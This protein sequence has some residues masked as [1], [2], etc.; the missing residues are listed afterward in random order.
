[1]L[2]VTTGNDDVSAISVKDGQ[3]HLAATTS[4]ISQKIA[5]VC[6]GW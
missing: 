3:D 6:C 2:Y 5:T 1:V 4:K